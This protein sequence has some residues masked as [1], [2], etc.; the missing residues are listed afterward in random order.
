LSSCYVERRGRLDD[1]AVLATRGKRAAF[2]LFYGPLHFLVV[3]EVVRRLPGASDPMAAV[4]DLGSGTGAAG[5]SWALGSSTLPIAAIERHPWAVAESSWTYRRFGLQGRARQ[6]DLTRDPWRA[7]PGAGI[8]AAYAINE[9]PVARRTAVL[10]R[11]VEAHERGSRVLVVE[12]IARAIAPWWDE[13]KGAVEREGGRADEWR[14]PAALPDRQ[15]ALARAA[16]LDPRT[17]TARSLWLG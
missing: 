12:P 16:G 1:G 17:L 7:A 5:A 11:L 3:R 8:L 15:R 13:W 4:I 2:A 10:E 6:G 9:V 14:F